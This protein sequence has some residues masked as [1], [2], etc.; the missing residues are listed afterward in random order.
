MSRGGSSSSSSSAQD[1]TTT[2]QTDSG[3]DIT[4]Q[5][6]GSKSVVG[7]EGSTAV[8]GKN[9]VVNIESVDAALVD[10]VSSDAFNTVES[11]AQESFS[12]AE[13][14]GGNALNVAANLGQ[15]AF[16]LA[17]ELSR[18]SANLAQGLTQEGFDLAGNLATESFD[19][20]DQ[21][22]DFVES[23]SGDLL[24]GVDSV[25][26]SNQEILNDTLSSVAG[27]SAKAIDA[28]VESSRSETENT[29]IKLIQTAAIVAGIF[30]VTRIF[31]K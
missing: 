9:N 7:T 10:A 23:L 3:G 18:E 11:I 25:L 14:L 24:S 5:V 28:A 13:N 20:V 1:L 17:D 2:G 4:G 15:D 30:L 12:T 21:N 16:S 8:G 22:I 26:T 19:L 29:N 31:K 27:T 6:A